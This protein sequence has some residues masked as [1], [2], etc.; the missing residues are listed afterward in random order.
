MSKT[1]NIFKLCKK[2]QPI[3]RSLTGAGNYQTLKIFKKINNRLKIKSF[4][5][6]SRVFDWKIPHEWNIRDGWVLDLKTKKKVIDFKKNML[7]IAGYSQPVDKLVNLQELKSKI[8]S[9]KSQT[10]A[11]PYV[12]FFYTK[13][14]A[15]CM[16][17]KDKKRLNGKKFRVKIDSKFTKGKMYYGEILIKGKLKKEILL[18][19]YIC[20]P[21]MANNEL[22]GPCV[23]IYLSKWLAKQKRKYSYRIIFTSETIGAISYIHK[24]FKKLKKN[25]IGGYVI[26]CVGDE[27]VYSYL[28]TK[29]ENTLSDKV[30]LETLKKIRAKKKIYN[31]K[32]RGSDERQFNSPGVDLNIGSIMR[33]KYDT[34]KEY[35]TSLDQLGSFVTAKGLK[36]SFQ[37]IKNVI[38]NLEKR[39]IPIST[40]NCEPFL[41]KR[42]LYFKPSIKGSFKKYNRT[43][44]DL[45][46]Y[47]DGNFSLNEIVEK[48]NVPIKTAKKIL[49]LLKKNKLI[50]Y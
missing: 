3:Y 22:S 11:T 5:S 42:N 38:L 32:S 50:T 26:T 41:S 34:Y 49:Q 29:K 21:F 36:Q 40:V 27:N 28:K 8:F 7:S 15:F 14:W 37:F 31:W 48:L 30:A 44:W 16:P 20:H 4:S 19:S 13:N 46:S 6:G 10:N 24:N 9:L 23:L 45:I 17:F 2:I 12:S 47:A 25:V 43:L 18:S 33:S 35:H 39:I 1:I